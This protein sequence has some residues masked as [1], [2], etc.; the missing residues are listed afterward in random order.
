MG[1]P[2]SWYGPSCESTH[3]VDL[4][5]LNRR[6]ML[7]LGYV[8]SLSWRSSG[9]RTGS[10]GFRSETT[11][12]RLLYTAIDRN[13]VRN[14]VN[15]LIPFICTPTPF[16]GRRRW[17][18]CTTCKKGCRVIYGQGLYFR[19]RTCSGLRY[20]SQ[21]EPAYQ[22]AIT[23]ADKIRRMVGDT[24]GGA[25]DRDQFPAK[26]S[27]MRWTTYKRLREMYDVATSSWMSGVINR[28]GLFRK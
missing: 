18:L 26:P 27:R 1:R 11:G 2:S 8:G 28:F 25:F 19:C 17:F 9:R 14:N 15:E 20:A 21:H 12:I 7:V 6:G 4:A 23:R 22:R 16:G 13:G 3:A 5:F 10:I 24:R